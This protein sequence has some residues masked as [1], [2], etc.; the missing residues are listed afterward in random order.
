MVTVERYIFI[1]CFYFLFHARSNTREK[2]L[3]PFTCVSVCLSSG[4]PL[5]ACHRISM[6]LWYWG[7]S[8]KKTKRWLK[9]GKNIGHFAWKPEY[10][11]LFLAT[12]NHYK[13]ALWLKWCQA[14]MASI[15]QH[16]LAPLSLHRVTWNFMLVTY[17]KICVG[18]FQICSKSGTST[19]RPNL[20]CFSGDIRLP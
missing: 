2:R 14:V 6:K 1:L 4:C 5:L 12:L 19:W 8:V 11:L 16:V 3:L 17:V 15:C 13:S 10:V 20:F 18:K 7:N 9:W